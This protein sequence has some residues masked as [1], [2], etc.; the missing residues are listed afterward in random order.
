M[1]SSE[2]TKVL[3]SVIRS[4]LKEIVKEAV[5]YAVAREF[6][7]LR[8]ELTKPSKQSVKSVKQKGSNITFADMMED[9]EPRQERQ[10]INEE[11]KYFKESPFADVLNQT[12]PFGKDD[13][14]ANPYQ[15]TVRMALR[16]KI[17]QE[18]GY[19]D[20]VNL[21]TDDIA[22]TTQEI[23]IPT[24][25]PDGKPINTKALES[26][27]GM[28]VLQNLTRNYSDVLKAAEKKSKFRKGK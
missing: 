24:Q 8:E 5:D 27:A 18:A 13:E 19:G 26:E 2:F 7:L 22:P 3:K 28:K 10:V 15:Q 1:K 11:K 16:Q 20:T 14:A 9:D 12:R 23:T 25:D 21:K 6:R 17:A 4:E